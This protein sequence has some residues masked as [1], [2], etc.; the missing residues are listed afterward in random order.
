MDL[1]WTG[2]LPTLVGALI[3]ATA[4]LFAVNRGFKLQRSAQQTDRAEAAAAAL[5][6]ALAQFV[7]GRNAQHAWSRFGAAKGTEPPS[8]PSCNSVSIALELLTMATYGDE[9]IV[10]RRFSTA[11]RNIANAKGDESGG[12]GSLAGAIADWRT[13]EKF[14][15][16]LEFDIRSAEQLAATP[17]GTESGTA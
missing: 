2:I 5:M 9:R 4:S 10:A 11:W 3:G 13:G 1:F 16:D 14:G 17:L 8:P 6:V 12:I 15:N 7:D